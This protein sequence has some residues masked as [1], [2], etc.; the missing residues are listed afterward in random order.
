MAGRMAGRIRSSRANG[1]N[2]A[3]V[4]TC[5][6]A[7]SADCLQAQAAAI[8]LPGTFG[9]GETSDLQAFGQSALLQAF[10][11]TSLQQ[12]FRKIPNVCGRGDS[13]GSSYSTVRYQYKK[14]KHLIYY[15]S[16]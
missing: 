7:W 8:A 9:C 11:Q 15:R 5:M 2:L 10:H 14:G 13:A 4:E 1:W 12:T 16:N 3:A 6:D